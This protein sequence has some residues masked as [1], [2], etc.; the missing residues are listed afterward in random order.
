MSH[1]HLHQS[2]SA[3]LNSLFNESNFFLYFLAR[4]NMYCPALIKRCNIV[5]IQHELCRFAKFFFCACLFYGCFLPPQHTRM[6]GPIFPE[7][8]PTS[9]QTSCI[10]PHIGRT[11][12]PVLPCPNWVPRRP[13]GLH[14]RTS[15][16]R[17]TWTFS[18]CLTRACLGKTLRKKGKRKRPESVGADCITAWCEETWLG[19]SPGPEMNHR[20]QERNLFVD[21]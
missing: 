14:H 19:H 1:S 7:G 6:E 16:I 12:H 4:I 20:V 8:P 13:P 18:T 9:H 10:P 15:T 5:G 2:Q 11:G 21:N 17:G 3:V